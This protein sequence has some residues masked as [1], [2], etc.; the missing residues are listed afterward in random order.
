MSKKFFASIALVALALGL[1][2]TNPAN[3]TGSCDGCVSK[4]SYGHHTPPPAPKPTS[5]SGSFEANAATA[6]M[7]YAVF[8]APHGNAAGGKQGGSY[9]WGDVAGSIN[10]CTSCPSVS[11]KFGAGGWENAWAKSVGF[12]DKSGVA[13]MGM[14]ATGASVI[15]SGKATIGK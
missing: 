6:G 11:A 4:P 9:A 2:I 13:A 3:A 10:G 1:G 12:S 8:D 15:G 5:V 14:N 7:Y